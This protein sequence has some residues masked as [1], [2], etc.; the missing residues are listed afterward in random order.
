MYRSINIPQGSDNKSARAGEECCNTQC[1]HCVFKK[2]YRYIFKI[3]HEVRGEKSEL[4][5]TQN[6]HCYNT[7]EKIYLVEKKKEQTAL[8][9]KKNNLQRSLGND[10]DF[11]ASVSF[12]QITHAA[13][14]IAVSLLSLTEQC[15]SV[16]EKACR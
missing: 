11:C 12:I 1:D 15:R 9:K 2:Q 4:E 6:K 16:M 3:Q 8:K 7:E 13:L 10:L 14:W 5:E